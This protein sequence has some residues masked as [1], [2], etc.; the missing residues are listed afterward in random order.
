MEAHQQV[1]KYVMSCIKPGVT[2]IEICKKLEDCS[3][4][5]TKQNGLNTGLVFPT[6]HSLKTVLP[7]ILPMLVSEEYYGVM[8]SVK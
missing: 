8:I 2:M 4:R 6:R 3:Q 7:T 1:R 5:L